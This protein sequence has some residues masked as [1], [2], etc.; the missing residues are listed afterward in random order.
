MHKDVVWQHKLAHICLLQMASAL[1]HIHGLGLVH[2]DV[3]PDNIFR[4]GAVFKLGDFG[5]AVPKD[6]RGNEGDQ[7]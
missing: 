6:G 7:K 3:K 5:L 2:M 1:M 4:K